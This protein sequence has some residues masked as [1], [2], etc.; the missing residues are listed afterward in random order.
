MEPP[1]TLGQ[2]QRLFA[3]LFGQLLVRI[4]EHGYECAL[5]EGY[6]PPM[7]AAYYAAI[8][9]GIARS[10]HTD[11]LAHDISL[12]KDGVYLPGTE[13]HREFGLWWEGLHPFCRW[14]GRFNDG[15]HYS[16]TH[17]GRS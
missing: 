8:G 6:R 10:L 2:K 12:F 15:G 1:L 9:K 17:G 5:E 4:Y 14:G 16:L 3:K 13:A 7:M 11:K